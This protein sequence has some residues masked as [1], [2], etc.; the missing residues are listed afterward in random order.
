MVTELGCPFGSCRILR[1]RGGDLKVAQRGAQMGD[2][3]IIDFEVRRKDD[4]EPLEGMMRERHELDCLRD[5][6]FLPGVM[7]HLM[8]MRVGEQKN[9]DFSFPDPWE[10]E[11]LAGL[12]AT[13]R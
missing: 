7:K 5:Q 6:N 3:L 13:V 4:Q 10:P 9:V 12:E 8:G 2:T 11:E 1:E